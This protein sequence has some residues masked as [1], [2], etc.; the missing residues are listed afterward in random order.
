MRT[1]D[2]V[3]S[4]VTQLMN[5]NGFN[6]PHTNKAASVDFLL[7]PEHGHATGFCTRAEHAVDKQ[8]T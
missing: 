6:Q 3:Q 4:V 2:R 1:N 5:V 8:P 7:H